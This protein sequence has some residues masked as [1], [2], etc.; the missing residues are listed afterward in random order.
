M[1][2]FRFSK[3]HLAI[4]NLPNTKDW[5]AELLTTPRTAID[6]RDSQGRTS[7]A[8]AACLGDVEAVRKLLQG[9]A[10]PNLADLSGLS[11]LHLAATSGDCRAVQCLDSLLQG[12]ADIDA[13]DVY[14]RTA[15]HRSIHYRKPESIKLL[16]D[17]GAE[18][19]TVDMNGTSLL[20]WAALFGNLPILST[21]KQAGLHGLNIN[22]VD[23]DSWTA[24]Q[25]AK[26]RRDRNA[27]WSGKFK[28]PEDRD[29]LKWFSAF[30][31]L[32][33][34]IRAADIAECYAD[35]VALTNGDLDWDPKE[36]SKQNSQE[37]WMSLP[38]SF[39]VE[40]G[41]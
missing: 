17:S 18:Y 5:S 32:L 28:L 8:W 40:D 4:L 9:G 25:C 12:G 31:E 41:E 19:Y 21:M 23:D 27:R 33:D 29:P 24:M 35:F 6:E 22:L 38:G 1:E 7:L 15:L 20:H 30:E 36:E 37:G 34:S 2:Y 3:L 16:L 11:P 26:W 10:D 13:C 14:G 39:P